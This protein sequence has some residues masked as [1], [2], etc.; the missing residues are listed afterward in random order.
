MNSAPKQ[1]WQQMLTLTEQM[2]SAAQSDDWT[3]LTE[4]QQNRDQ[5]MQRL[6]AASADNAALIEATLELNQ[7]LELLSEQQ[8]QQLTRQVR[9]GQQTRQGIHAYQQVTGASH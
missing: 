5:L 3:R 2:V 7:Q 1:P 9:R 8:R 4:L 6:P